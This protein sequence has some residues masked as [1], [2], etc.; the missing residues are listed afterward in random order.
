MKA[1]LAKRI[2]DLPEYVF[3]RLNATK[4]ARRR[5]GIDIIDLGMGN[6]SDPTPEPIV[7]K[8]IEVARQ[9]RNHRYS[10]S[11][12]GIANLK[13]SVAAFYDR[14]YGVELDP[15]TEV[16]CTIGSK[17]GI[18]HL[19]LALVDHGDT[20]IVPV[21]AFPPHLYSVA[22]AGGRFVNVP[23]GDTPEFFDRLDDLVPTIEPKPKMLILNFPHNPTALTVEPPY[24]ERAVEFGRRHDIVIMHDFAYSHVTFDGYR[25]PSLLQA[26]GAKDVGVEFSTLSK[27]FNMAGWRVGFCVGN[28]DI[29]QALARV[30]G[31]YDYGLFMPVQIAAIIA[32]RDCAD[33]VARQAAIYQERRD[34]LCRGL[35]QYG[36]DVPS[37]RGSMFVWAPLPEPLRAMGSVEFC[38]MLLNEANV[39]IA[40]GSA[41]G[42]AGD[43]FVR[44]AIV[45]KKQRLQQAVRQIGRALRAH[46][47]TP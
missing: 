21:P 30:K 43:G 23:V 28:R 26:P 25:A 41:F 32:L 16:I 44:M 29:V 14:E 33:H 11:A 6:P 13:R 40:P 27:S 47:P 36:W 31:Y 39:A 2:A 38:T 20:V 45:E 3:G 8:L 9:P 17:E 18:S 4:L 10:V 22:F 34:V 12:D 15:E 46:C 1:K 24:F 7:E 42:A 19:S 37:P 5:E 35:A